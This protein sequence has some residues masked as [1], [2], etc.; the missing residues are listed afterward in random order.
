MCAD[1]N[2]VIQVELLQ[3]GPGKAMFTYKK[4]FNISTNTTVHAW[5]E[6]AGCERSKMST[7]IFRK[8]NSD[9]KITSLSGY[10]AQYTA[11][12]DEALVDGMRGSTDFR[13]GTWQGFSGKNLEAVIDLGKEQAITTITLSCLQEIKS[14]IWFPSEIEIMIS[15]DGKKFSSAGVIT[16][17]LPQ[18][19]Y[20]VLTHE[21]TKALRASGR[22][23]KIIAHPAFSSIPKWHPGVGGTPWIF[24]DEIII[25]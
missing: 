7:A 3:D 18:D 17:D 2:A 8:R 15:H 25:R 19:D 13:T 4:P 1:T 23:V 16:N 20:T 10:D 12:G 9:V 22:Y 11:G 6:V 24:A 14:W 5:A 21:F